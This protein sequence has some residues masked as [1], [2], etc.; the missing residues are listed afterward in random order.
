MT[1]E[2][3][4][5]WENCH[6][7]SFD[8]VKCIL[9]A[10]SI[11]SYFDL[12]KKTE[13][14]VDAS[15]VGLGTILT[16]KGTVSD[17]N[18]ISYTS[19]A[20]SDMEKHYPQVHREAHALV[21]GVIHYSIYFRGSPQFTIVSDNNTVVHIFNSASSSPPPHIE[22]MV[23][24]VQQFNVKVVHKS[25]RDTPADYL[26]RHPDEGG[27]PPQMMSAKRATSILLFT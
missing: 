25:G 26:S 14:V 1:A 13:L 24:K 11:L 23:M 7:V 19:W 20:L 3:K 27:H 4:F 22:C 10:H 12:D 16:Q 18:V 6:T 5:I 9:L 21:W 15:P 17:M 2:S 8:A